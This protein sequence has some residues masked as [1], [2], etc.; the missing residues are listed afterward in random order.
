MKVEAAFHGPGPDRWGCTF[1]IAGLFFFLLNE[2]AH[3]A[4]VLTCSNN[5]SYRCSCCSKTPVHTLHKV[6]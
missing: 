3:L 4:G 5:I 2:G 6:H 1:V